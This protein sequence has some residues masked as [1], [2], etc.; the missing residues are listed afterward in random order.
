M[1]RLKSCSGNSS[2]ASFPSLCDRAASAPHKVREIEATQQ[3]IL[4][5]P[6]Y[7]PRRLIQKKIIHFKIIR[8]YHIPLRRETPSVL[9]QLTPSNSPSDSSSNPFGASTNN[10]WYDPSKKRP[11]T[12]SM[13]TAGPVRNA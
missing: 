1:T 3:G 10:Q 13:D 9:K 6:N 5:I 7:P 4:S 11:F 8:S 2:A 12:S